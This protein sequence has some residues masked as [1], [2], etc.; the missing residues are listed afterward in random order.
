VVLVALDD[1]LGELDQVNLPGTDGEYPNWRRKSRATLEEITRDERVA[2]I[3]AEVEARVRGG[4][5]A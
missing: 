3:A 5:Q 4:Q 2:R 1:A